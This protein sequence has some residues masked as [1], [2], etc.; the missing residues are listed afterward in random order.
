MNNLKRHVAMFMAVAMVVTSLSGVSAPESVMAAGKSATVSTQK[1]LD[2]AL[3]DAK[4]GTITIKTSAKKS[5]EVKKGNYVKKALT[6]NA[7]KASIKNSGVFKSVAVKDAATFTENAKGNSLKVTDSKLNIVIGKSASIKKIT[8][9]KSGAKDT[10][11]VNG[12]L[13]ALTV[14]A[15]SSVSLKGSTKTKTTVNIKATDSKITSDNKIA[16]V[17]YKP[18][19]VILKENAKGSTIKSEA[20]SAVVTV[21]NNTGADVKVTKA[22]GTVSTVA[23]GTTIVVDSSNQGGEDRPQNNNNNTNNGNNYIGNGGSGSTG[24]AGSTGG[25]GGESGNTGSGS[26]A[27]A[28]INSI[29]LTASVMD[30]PVGKSCDIVYYATVDMTKGDAVSDVTLQTG[31]DNVGQ[32]TMHD[33]GMSGDDIAGD[34]VYSCRV[35]AVAGTKGTVDSVVTAG[36]KTDKVSFNAYKELTE[37]DQEDIIK[38]QNTLKNSVAVSSNTFSA[39]LTGVENLGKG[40]SQADVNAAYAT[41]NAQVKV[42]V[43]AAESSLNALVASDSVDSFEIV[44]NQAIV[45]MNNG[46]TLVQEIYQIPNIDGGSGDAGASGGVTGGVVNGVT[47][48]SDVVSLQP[49]RNMYSGID[50]FMTYPDVAAE[51]VAGREDFVFNANYDNWDVSIETLKSL[52]KYDVIVWHG[53]GG[54]APEYGSFLL[55][56]ETCDN[57]FAY[58]ADFMADRLLLTGDNR[59][60][61]TAKFFED[62]YN[63]GAFDDAIIYL[64][65]CQS[66]YDSQNRLVNAFLNAGA[67]AVIANSDTIYTCYNTLMEKSFFTSLAGSD[68]TAEAALA[69]AKAENGANDVEWVG[70]QQE[71]HSPAEPKIF[72]NKDYK[73]SEVHKN[74]V[75]E[76]GSNLSF[77]DGFA[78]WTYSGD[79]RV[80]SALQAVH[81]TDGNKFAVIGTGLGVMQSKD[82]FI[83]TKLTVPAGMS[84]LLLDYDMISEEL[85]EFHGSVYDDTMCIYVSSKQKVLDADNPEAVVKE[86]VNSSE[87]IE[88]GANYFADGDETTYHTGMKTAQIDLTDYITSQDREVVLTIMIWD[89]GDSIY[90]SA[91]AV[92][93]IRFAN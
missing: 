38:A 3:K 90:D 60:I 39:A 21:T 22:D 76:V 11:T 74:A 33:D 17:A 66:G 40:A 10:I 37:K 4:I 73:L 63:D 78:G 92:D 16:V 35:A 49:C 18:A 42:A 51:A 88:L 23:N 67:E 48:V 14:S 13:K 6:I 15:K 72:G 1:Q 83:Q 87:W 30:V 56:G 53:H 19:E 28:T 36:G 32:V 26:G 52:A 41:Y 20:K 62:Y 65:A 2:A 12:I 50:E 24:G 57:P 25:T 9:A 45:E 27:T 80:L 69:N 54:F 44:Q 55:T 34:H 58:A 84:K 81:P 8:L 82:N 47:A 61:V 75:A 77:E 43:A 71:N 5:L 70:Y 86:S 64:G 93:N 79:S 31:F 85:M 59:L 29:S 68:I 7:P 91:V 89:E 46:V